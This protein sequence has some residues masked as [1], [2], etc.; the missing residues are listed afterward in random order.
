MSEKPNDIT[1]VKIAISPTTSPQLFASRKAENVGLQPR[2]GSPNTT[3]NTWELHF[4]GNC[5]KLS[6]R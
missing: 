5:T 3:K 4:V 2:K 6:S 1:V